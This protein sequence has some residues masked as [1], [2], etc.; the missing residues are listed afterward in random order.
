MRYASLRKEYTYPNQINTKIKPVGLFLGNI[1]HFLP[2]AID[3]CM[4]SFVSVS[5]S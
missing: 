1:L 4:M 5:K 2:P 3:F